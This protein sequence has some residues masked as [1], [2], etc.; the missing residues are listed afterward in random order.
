MKEFDGALR[1]VDQPEWWLMPGGPKGI[2]A[3]SGGPAS[4]LRT[5]L[6]RT[7]R[8]G[9]FESPIRVLI[10]DDHPLMRKMM[11]EVLALDDEI[12]VVGSAEDGEEALKVLDEV[13]PDV[14]VLDFAMPGAN[15]IDVMEEIHERSPQPVLMVSIHAQPYLVERARRAGALGYLSKISV[16]QSLA[17]AIH[18]VSEGRSYFEA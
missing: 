5:A 16:A 9:V 8:V 6:A 3:G 13:R 10:V 18:A 7:A 14:V 15:G 12:E 4:S 1:G 17:P 11:G 2:N